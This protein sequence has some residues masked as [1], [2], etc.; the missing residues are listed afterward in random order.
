MPRLVRIVVGVGESGGPHAAAH[1]VRLW[2]VPPWI[3]RARGRLIAASGRSS[4]R[5][6]APVPLDARQ[7]ETEAR[8]T[9]E[10][11]QRLAFV[12]S[13]GASWEAPP[14]PI[15]AEGALY[16]THAFWRD[17]IGRFDDRKT[18]WPEAV[19]R[20]LITLKAMIYEPSG[21]LVAAPTTSLPEARAEP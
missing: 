13:Y 9:I 1:A 12:L 21:G 10:A 11:G 20:S 19:R 3:E 6:R 18:R 8:F 14:Q 15:D 2:Q 17:W 4:S 7:D 16:A 5:S